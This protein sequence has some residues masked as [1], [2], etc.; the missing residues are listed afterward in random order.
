MTASKKKA[1]AHTFSVTAENVADIDAKR[2]AQSTADPFTSALRVVSAAERS[3]FAWEPLTP[4]MRGLAA[5]RASSASPTN[6]ART[7]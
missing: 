7:I 5:L 3:T 2:L 6:Y 4:G 1:V